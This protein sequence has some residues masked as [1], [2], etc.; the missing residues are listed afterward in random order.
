MKLLFDENISRQ[1]PIAISDLFPHSIH[2]YE[3]NLLSSSDEF[4]WDYAKSFS[5]SI[6]SKDSD[7]LQRSFIFGHPPKVIWL[8]VG[9][10]TTAHI[11][12]LLKNNVQEIASFLSSQTDSVLIVSR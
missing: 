4:I 12:S 10:C 6:V 7:F 3:V 9:N 11:V 2:V 1:V 5:F 8:N